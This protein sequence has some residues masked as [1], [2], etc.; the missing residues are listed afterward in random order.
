VARLKPLTTE[1]KIQESEIE[2]GKWMPAKEFSS[3][4]Y[5]TGLYKKILDIE[6]ANID[7]KYDGWVVENLPIGFRPG[8]NNLYHGCKL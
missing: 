5:Y 1:I 2:D 3:L 4:P 7:G 8:T 6:S